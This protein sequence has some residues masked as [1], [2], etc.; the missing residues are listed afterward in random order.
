MMAANTADL[1]LGNM[2]VEMQIW[3]GYPLDLALDAL[4]EV[5]ETGGDGR[6]RD[7]VLEVVKFRKW[8][9]QDPLPW[10]TQAFGHFVFRWIRQFGGEVERMAFVKE[11][12]EIRSRCPRSPEGLV[13]HTDPVAA[14]GTILIDF[15]QSYATRLVRAAAWSDDDRFLEEAAWQ[16]RKHRTLLRNPQTGLW[17]QGL[18]WEPHPGQISPGAWSRGHGWLVHGLVN[19]LEVICPNSS[20]FRELHGYFCELVD[21]LL[22]LQDSDGFWHCLLHLPDSDSPPETSGTALI[23]HALHRALAAGWIAGAPYDLAAGRAFQA[24][25]SRVDASGNVLGACPGPGPL[26]NARMENY[27]RPSLPEDFPHG[28]FTALYSCAGRIRTEMAPPR[29]R[30]GMDGAGDDSPKPK[31]HSPM[32]AHPR[33]GYRP[34]RVPALQVPVS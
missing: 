32:D 30:E 20:A 12:G 18:G 34:G 10:H 31:C 16:W 7:H 25:A 26:N 6:Y 14:N 19:S 5:Y 17:H 9:V 27:R 1:I 28:R 2:R 8:R 24:A 13:L 4:L 11:T 23:S 3:G 29:S 21:S 33:D 22:P 15:M